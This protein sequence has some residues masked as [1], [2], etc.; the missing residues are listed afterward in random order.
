MRLTKATDAVRHLFA[1][2][3][4]R[5][6]KPVRPACVAPGV[7]ITDHDAWAWLEVPATNSDLMTDAER[8]AE[9]KSVRAA[10]TA[11]AGFDI[12]LKILWDEHDSG[13]Y[14]ASV[15]GDSGRH[16]PW[17]ELRAET[18]EELGLP[19]RVV[20]LGVRLSTKMRGKTSARKKAKKAHATVSSDQ[21]NGAM[22]EAVRVAQRLPKAPADGKKWGVKLASTERLMWMLSRE[23]D[24]GTT[25][26]EQEVV[27]G[28][29]LAQ[30]GRFR[31]DSL[32]TC[33][34]VTSQSGERFSA[35][36]A[37]SEFP[38]ISG[39]GQEWAAML[40][41]LS[42]TVDDGIMHAGV[43]LS[44]RFEV[45]STKDASDL[46]AR[47]RKNALE[48]VN[49]ASRSEVAEVPQEVL[50]TLDDTNDIGARLKRGNTSL[51]HDHTRVIVH[52]MDQE[53][54]QNKV[55]TVVQS[56]GEMG[57]TATLLIDE[58]MEAWQE[59][60][61]GEFVRIED[62]PQIRET[63]NFVSSWFWQGSAVGETASDASV[64][65]FTTGTTCGPVRMD[66]RK[67]I[68]GQHPPVV[69]LTGV[70]RY[71]KTTTALQLMMDALMHPQS[72]QPWGVI[73]DLKGDINGHGLAALCQE[74][75]LPFSHVE[76]TEHDNGTLDPF[77]TVHGAGVVDEATAQ[78]MGLLPTGDARACEGVITHACANVL[79]TRGS[80][81]R[82]WMVVDEL[83][84]LAHDVAGTDKA[85]VLRLAVDGLRTAQR[86]GLGR[87]IV[88]KP[89]NGGARKLQ[90]TH[91]LTLITVPGASLPS[92]KES[93]D[94]WD[95]P[96]RSSSAALRGIFAWVSSTVQQPAMRASH[97]VAFFPECHLLTGT[98]AGRTALERAS[99]MWAAFGVSLLLDTQD[100]ASLTHAGFR[101]GIGLTFAFGQQARE[102][103]RAACELLGL[104][105]SDDMCDMVG[106]L[107][108]SDEW[109]AREGHAI[110]R[111]HALVRDRLGRV[112]SVQI[113]VPPKI[114]KLLDTS[115]RASAE[116][117][118][119]QSIPEEIELA[120]V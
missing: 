64:V 110:R 120:S 40:S 10:L 44:S 18:M 59:C 109:Q 89:Q 14:V 62:L 69:C 25:C 56:F 53:T 108:D 99:R 79:D 13:G 27:S 57:I 98:Q 75:G 118:A 3:S 115:N 51:M 112:A 63:A 50:D 95:A 58:Q 48:Q 30:L 71:G 68:D 66:L 117:I 47:V 84:R 61:P 29:E 31:V 4:K 2:G 111:G 114:L 9:E 41:D 35:V 12:H 38:E 11:L 8:E 22:L 7:I 82:S 17:A 119:A 33:V 19:Q 78:L 116:R 81:A 107:G 15:S 93:S 45:L 85:T 16:S 26:V 97:K 106:G 74:F 96:Q 73:T 49:A 28:A 43:E 24:L 60:Q 42:V 54:L 86:H 34:R 100:A 1:G 88:G 21:I 70:T 52:A 80:A 94:R 67:A 103:Q 5:T 102:S 90:A 36:L 23:S 87:L 105:E 39:E 72:R 76:L 104:E 55:S 113:V 77:V 20:L 37:L 83:D 46:T 6:H 65:G 92:A 91:G 32:P 101:E